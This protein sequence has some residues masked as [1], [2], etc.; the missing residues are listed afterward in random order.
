MCIWLFTLVQFLGPIFPQITPLCIFR[1]IGGQDYVE[2]PFDHPRP[3]VCEVDRLCED[4]V[5]A[6]V[7]H[8]TWV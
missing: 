3:A 5:A 8:S 6:L 4:P 7:T 2:V 1:I